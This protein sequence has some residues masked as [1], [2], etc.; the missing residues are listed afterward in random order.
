MS[1]KDTQVDSEKDCDRIVK[2]INN[3]GGAVFAGLDNMR[4]GLSSM[5]YNL[6]IMEKAADINVGEI[7]GFR[8][9]FRETK[10]VLELICLELHA[11]NLLKRAEMFQGRQPNFSQS[12]ITEAFDAMKVAEDFVERKQKELEK[13]KERENKKVNNE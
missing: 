8:K 9:D 1:E 12:F 13:K 4:G 11:A 7:R 2:A 5:G 3:L 6:S 10:E